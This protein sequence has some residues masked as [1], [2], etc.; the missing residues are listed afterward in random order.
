[1]VSRV[2]V[3]GRGLWSFRAY[4]WPETRPLFSG[5]LRIKTIRGNP[6]PQKKGRLFFPLEVRVSEDPHRHSWDLEEPGRVQSIDIGLQIENPYRI[7]ASSPVSCTQTVRPLL[8]PS[9][10][11]TMSILHHYALPCRDFH[12]VPRSGIGNVL[13]S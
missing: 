11:M 1:M 6:P 3:R 10:H 4:L 5:S 13:R 7:H 8:R 2:Q 12:S 9:R